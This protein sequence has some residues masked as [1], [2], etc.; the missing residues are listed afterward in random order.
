[1]VSAEQLEV[2]VVGGESADVDEP[3]L[4]SRKIMIAKAAPTKVVPSRVV[5]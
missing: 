4:R 5:G 3:L 2:L 1:V